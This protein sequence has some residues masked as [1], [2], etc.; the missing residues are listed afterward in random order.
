MNRHLPTIGL[1]TGAA[2]FSSALYLYMFTPV[3]LALVAV[4]T[5]ISPKSRPFSTGVFAAAVGSVVFILVLAIGQSVVPPGVTT[6][7]P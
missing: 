2:L 4:A 7:G 3:L 1:L 5:Y 6:Y